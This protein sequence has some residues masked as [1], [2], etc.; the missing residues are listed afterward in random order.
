MTAAT[1]TALGPVHTRLSQRAD[2]SAAD[3]TARLYALVLHYQGRCKQQVHE[4]ALAVTDRADLTRKLELAEQR[5]DYLLAD[6]DKLASDNVEKAR[7]IALLKLD[8]RKRAALA[9]NNAPGESRIDPD[10]MSAEPGRALVTADWWPRYS[11][12]AAMLPVHG[13]GMAQ[14]QARTQLGVW[15]DWAN[16]HDLL[17][18][19][20]ITAVF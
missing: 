19:D 15:P 20:P 17:T 4:L 8:V 12:M 16:D 3:Y 18:D 2:E 9:D 14:A 6:L 13:Y 10:L 5:N 7:T 1:M 11:L